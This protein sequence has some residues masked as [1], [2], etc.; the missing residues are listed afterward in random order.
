VSCDPAAASYAVIHSEL[1]I[2]PL[3]ARCRDATVERIASRVAF[4]ADPG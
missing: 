3:L 4:V 1:T 2:S